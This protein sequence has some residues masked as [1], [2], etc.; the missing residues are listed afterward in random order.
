MRPKDLKS[1]FKW[2]ER[3]P[4]IKDQVLYVPEYYGK[5]EEF[6]MPSFVEIFGNDNP[7]H[8]EYCSGHG[9]WIVEKAKSQPEVNWVAVER[10]FERVRKIF[11]KRANHNVSN[12]LIV[13]GE[14]YTFS[15]CYLKNNVAQE[16]FINFPDP[17]PKQRHAKHRLIKE[18]FLEELSRTLHPSGKLSV[19][20]DDER[21]SD[22]VISLVQ[23]HPLWAPGYAE[24]YYKT[25]V[26]NYGYSFFD[27]LWRKKGKLIRYMQFNNQKN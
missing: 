3:V 7:V 8:I 17:W 20:T 22:E 15:K 24:P 5:H 9:D 27:S 26:D 18:S 12:L 14:G 10:Q 25:D 11:S 19:V 23:D 4:Y 13:C 1:L 16:V 6:T 21:Y 2:E